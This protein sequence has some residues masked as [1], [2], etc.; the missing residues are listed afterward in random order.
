VQAWPGAE[1]DAQARA[2][3]TR[4]V[5]LQI[6][7]LKAGV[8]ELGDEL[9]STQSQLDSVRQESTQQNAALQE[10]VDSTAA[11]NDAMRNAVETSALSIEAL[12]TER[13]QLQQD[14]QSTKTEL[15]T[16]R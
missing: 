8:R 9:A 6:S 14:L 3:M 16:V 1:P 4:N 11:E 12:T 13:D 15:E 5:V 10:K 2:T 7:K